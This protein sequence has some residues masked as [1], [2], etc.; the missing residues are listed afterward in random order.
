MSDEVKDIREFRLLLLEL[1]N[2]ASMVEFNTIPQIAMK[3]KDLPV[4]AFVK[5][6]PEFT[7][8]P[9]KEYLQ[10]EG[11]LKLSEFEKREKNRIETEKNCYLQN[12]FFDIQIDKISG[13][14]FFMLDESREKKKEL[15]EILHM[16]GAVLKKTISDQVDY[17]VTSKKKIPTMPEG[18]DDLAKAIELFQKRQKPIF[19]NGDRLIVSNNEWQNMVWENETICQKIERATKMNNEIYGKI[20]KSVPDDFDTFS[21]R[22]TGMS[23]LTISQRNPDVKSALMFNE[24]S[25]KPDISHSLRETLKRGGSYCLEGLIGLD[26]IVKLLV[27]CHVFIGPTSADIELV[28]Y[29]RWTGEWGDRISFSFPEAVVKK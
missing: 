12:A 5:K 13:T 22:A 3:N 26:Y 19:I 10:H 21:C 1:K 25:G 15:S 2:R 28:Q 11:I 8:E 9:A 23:S 7:G 18:D 14:G 16:H 27:A 24:A 17:F 4:L 29:S 6:I 20:E